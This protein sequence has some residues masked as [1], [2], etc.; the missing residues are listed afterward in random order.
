MIKE[1]ITPELKVKFKESIRKTIE[2]R[3]EHEFMSC[4][5]DKWMTVVK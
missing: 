2:T 4:K 3:L 5:D 1:K